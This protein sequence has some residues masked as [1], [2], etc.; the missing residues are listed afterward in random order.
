MKFRSIA[1]AGLAALALAACGEQNAPAP[2]AA[3]TP[4]PAAATPAPAASTG[5]SAPAQSD[6]QQAPAAAQPA[7]PAT[8]EQKKE[9][10]K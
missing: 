6:A 10:Q 8:M 4:A 2:K 5:A 7:A 1:M 3:S 9:E